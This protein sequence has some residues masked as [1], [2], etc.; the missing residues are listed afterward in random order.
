[1]LGVFMIL[2]TV[3]AYVYDF[4]QYWNQAVDAAH[5]PSSFK[6]S[7]RK[8]RLGLDLQ[9]GAHL[10]YD[11]NMTQIPDPDRAE[12]LEG[13]KNVIEKRVNTF[14]VSEPLVQTM[15]TQGTYRLVVELAGIKDV[16]EAIA[17]IGQ[18]PVLEFM[19]PGKDVDR[20]LTDEEK[21][22]LKNKQEQD[23]TNARAVLNRALSG[24]NFDSLISEKSLLSPEQSLLKGITPTSRYAQFKMLIDQKKLD[25]SRVSPTMIESEEGTSIFRLEEKGKTKEMLLSHIL[26]CFEGTKACPDPISEIEANIKINNLKQQVTA[27]AFEQIESAEDLGW[28]TPDKYVA[29]FA[30]AALALPIGSVSGIVQTEF[31]YHLIFKRNEREVNAYTVKRIL[32]PLTRETDIVPSSS[33]WKNTALS[34]KQLRR[35]SVQFDQKTGIPSILIEF[36]SEGVELFGQLTSSHVG[37]PIAIFL[38]GRLLSAP[39][40]QE[41]IYGGQATITGDFRENEQESRVDAAKRLARNLN[42]GALPVPIEL[43][44]QQTVGPTLGEVSLQKSIIAAL[45]G[46]ALIA[47]FMIVFYR[48]L[49]LVASISLVLF[50]GLNLVAYRF[51][52]VTISLAGIAGFVLSMGIAVDAN[53]LIFA[54]MKEEFAA[55]RDFH[56]TLD[57]GFA[58]AWTAIRDGHLT[59]LIAALVLYW[60]S[61]SFIRGFALTLSI[62]V[63]LSLFTAITVTRV[64]LKNMLAWKWARNPAL[65]ALKKQSDV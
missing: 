32:M 52:D 2:L 48:M 37:D 38:D 14:G 12:A 21:K 46:F 34:G 44:S 61:S 28:A 50:A 49:G 26:V 51:F 16:S 15:S 55:G 25:V 6:V 24:E 63:M 53:V 9:G 13:V 47:A 1:M 11:A 20:P 3:S 27:A 62:G 36:N 54:R 58:R 64:Y 45:A 17:Q 5:V 40:V 31:G 65:L 43:I 59:T 10:L 30:A 23:R 4:P 7:E 18:T 35:A 8:Y 56:S 42:A 60:F 19:E 39:I 22:E 41:A 57:E 29:P 33:P